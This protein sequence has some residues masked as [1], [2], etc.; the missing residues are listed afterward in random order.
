M[1]ALG[2][3]TLKSYDQQLTHLMDLIFAMGAHVQVLAGI[4]KQALHM[5]EEA[6]VMQ[7]K[8][9]DK[10]INRLEGLLEMAATE[11]LALQNPLAVDLRFVTSA[12]KIS[13]MLE[14]AGDLAKNV[15]KRSAHL[16]G[17]SSTETLAA[18]EHMADIVTDML[19]DALDAVK[20]RDA[21][22]ALD[23]WKRDDEVDDLYHAVFSA[24][25]REM[26]ESAANIP[27]CTHVVFMAKNL[28]RMADYVTNLAKT[29]HYIVT[30]HP[31]DKSL[32][33]Q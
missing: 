4:A 31:A 26:L 5:R 20:R 8:A 10:E 1:N 7:A 2:T 23:V 18:L 11:T 30:G 24:V 13:A 32:L 19:N 16:G 17:Y 21:Q 22:K 25:Q 9:E 14:R 15:V 3:H 28:E 27:S 6:L 12:L 29:V 33:K